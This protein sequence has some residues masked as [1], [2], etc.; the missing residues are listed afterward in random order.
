MIWCIVRLFSDAPVCE[1]NRPS[2][3]ARCFAKSGPWTGSGTAS[4]YSARVRPDVGPIIQLLISQLRNI[5]EPWIVTSCNLVGRYQSSL[6][7][8]CQYLQ[9]LWKTEREGSFET[10][11]Q[12]YRTLRHQIPADVILIGPIHR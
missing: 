10:S 4:A 5:T 11:V 1:A 3:V 7:N 12:I 2:L 9:D 6:A 8:R